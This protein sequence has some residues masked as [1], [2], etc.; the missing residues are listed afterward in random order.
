VKSAYELA[1]ERLD[2]ESG[3]AKKLSDDQKVRIADIEKKYDAKVAELRLDYDAQMQGAPSLEDLDK[4]KTEM[5]GKLTALEADRDK[6]K[7]AV[8][9]EA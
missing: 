1:M 7:D 9:N 3:P 5:A 8:W 4:L 2:R 6:E